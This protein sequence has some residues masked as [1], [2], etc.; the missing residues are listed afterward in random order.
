LVK[1]GFLYHLFW[2]R[3]QSLVFYVIFDGKE[4][5]VDRLIL[6]FLVVDGVQNIF[7]FGV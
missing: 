6:L 2:K 3:K 1:V 5:F 4:I 7:L